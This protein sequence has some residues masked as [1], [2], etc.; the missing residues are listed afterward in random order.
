MSIEESYPEW[1]IDVTKDPNPPCFC[2]FERDLGAV[3][4]GMNVISGKCPG[5]LVGVVHLGGQEEV[6][7]WIAANPDWR[8]RFSNEP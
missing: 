7:K 6:E 4:W 5:K 3:V 8:E 2:P 1:V